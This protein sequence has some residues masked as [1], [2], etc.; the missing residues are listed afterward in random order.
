MDKSIKIGSYILFDGQKWSKN[1]KSKVFNYGQK[2]SVEYL[3]DKN[4]AHILLKGPLNKNPPKK[5]VE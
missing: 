3:A 1:E 4:G 2:W 5:S